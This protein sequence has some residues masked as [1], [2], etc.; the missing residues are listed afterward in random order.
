MRPIDPK[1]LQA[2]QVFPLALY[3]RRGTKLLGAGIE[4]TKDAARRLRRLP[5]GWVYMART[6]GELAAA[7]VLEK[8]TKG[9]VESKRPGGVVYEDA[10][11][12]AG[13]EDFEMPIQFEHARRRAAMLKMAED[14]VWRRE[15][16]WALI[17]GRSA[18]DT[19]TR[20]VVSSDGRGWPAASELMRLRGTD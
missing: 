8:R 17:P 7:G 15:R 18:R 9:L 1:T 19:E 10:R 3:S 4:L 5:A 11:G 12:L 14:I 2:G 13:R 16:I 6:V 20:K